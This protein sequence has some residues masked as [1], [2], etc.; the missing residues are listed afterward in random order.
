MTECV[1]P[2]RG[3]IYKINFDSGFI[4][5]FVGGSITR[6]V[7]GFLI[8]Y[9]SIYCCILYTIWNIFYTIYFSTDRMEGRLK[10]HMV[11]LGMSRARLGVLFGVT[12][13]GFTEDVV[14]L[15]DIRPETGLPYQEPMGTLVDDL[16]L[17]AGLIDGVDGGE[18]VVGDEKG[19]VGPEGVR[20]E[21]IEGGGVVGFPRGRGGGEGGFVGFQVFTGQF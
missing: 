21:G 7:N 15:V 10:P 19:L 12:D 11:I 2:R 17:V 6:V 4:G 5:V 18:T 14:H 20:D 3:P 8:L 9:D 16:L 13:G 1:D